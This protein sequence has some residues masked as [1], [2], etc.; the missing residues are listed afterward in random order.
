MHTTGGA[1]DSA[2]QPVPII[3][4]AF[5]NDMWWS[6][7]AELSAQIYQKYLGGEDAGYTWDWGDSRSG[8]WAPEGV[9]TKINRYTI[10][11]HTWEQVNIDNGRRRSV[12]LVFV[13]GG[14]A[15]ANWNGQI[16]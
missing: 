6:I 13:Y 12:R 9:K 7:P 16:P 4:V 11:F 5:K 15:E 3:E 14:N 8:S 2:A 10:D 1:R